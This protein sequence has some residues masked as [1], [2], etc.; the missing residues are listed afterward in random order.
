MCL[1]LDDAIEAPRNA[2]QNVSRVASPRSPPI[3]IRTEAFWSQ[4]SRLED[5][6]TPT[7]TQNAPEMTPTSMLAVTTIRCT[8]GVRRRDARCAAAPNTAVETIDR[9]SKPAALWPGT[10]L[11]ANP[12]RNTQRVRHAISATRTP[13]HTRASSLCQA[14][15][16]RRKGSPQPVAPGAA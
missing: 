7:F 14:A 9:Q 11:V 4:L 15:S 12:L 3:S 5:H 16:K 6:V 1:P 8:V 13:V 2:T 10:K